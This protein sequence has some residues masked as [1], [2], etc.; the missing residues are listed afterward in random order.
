MDATYWSPRGVVTNLGKVLG[1][2]WSYTYATSINAAGDILVNGTVGGL[3]ESAL[4][5][6]SSGSTAETA[7]PHFGRCL[8]P[9][10]HKRSSLVMED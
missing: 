6:Y 7:H 1:P 9:Q 4:L 8:W 10:R 5:V 2:S 3:S